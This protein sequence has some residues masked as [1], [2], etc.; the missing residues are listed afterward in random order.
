MTALTY[1]KAGNKATASAKLD[2]NVF[3]ML[4]D[5]HELVKAAYDAYLSNRRRNYAQTKSRGEISGGG[6]KP[7]RQKGTGR[8]RF[9]SSRNPIWRGGGVAFGPT[10][11]ENYTHKLTVKAKRQAI[12]QA[13]SMSVNENR[14]IIIEDFNPVDGKTSQAFK[15]MEKIGARGDILLAIDSK[16][17]LIE[18]ATRNLPNVKTIQAKYINVFDIVNADVIIMSQ[19]ALDLV[20]SWLILSKEAKK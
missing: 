14:L 5:N 4:P 9:G 13:L 3:G 15:L 18:Q 6:R 20:H 1:T 19:K 12:R 17:A 7:W 16:D 11:Q 2:K 10:G 8:A